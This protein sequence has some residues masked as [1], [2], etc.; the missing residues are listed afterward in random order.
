MI[1]FQDKI[2]YCSLCYMRFSEK[3]PIKKGPVHNVYSSIH[4]Y[5]YIYIYIYNI[6]TCI[7]NGLYTLN[8]FIL[9]SLLMIKNYTTTPFYFFHEHNVQF[10]KNSKLMVIL[11][12]TF[13]L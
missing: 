7:Y 11:F 3:V 2:F 10:D 5:I 9:Q 1:Q 4:L 8:L 12:N 13:I 6:G